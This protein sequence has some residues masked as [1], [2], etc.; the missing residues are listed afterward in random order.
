MLVLVLLGF[1]ILM[2]FALFYAGQ[3]KSSLL[4]SLYL[5]FQ[6]NGLYGNS[7]WRNFSSSIVLKH[8]D[9]EDFK[10]FAL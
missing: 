2:I 3:H 4:L 5:L 7:F 6:R 8:R 9:L 1:A 10:E